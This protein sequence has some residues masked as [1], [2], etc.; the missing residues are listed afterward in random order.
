MK[1]VMMFM[2]AFI[3]CIKMSKN[4][5][6]PTSATSEVKEIIW[7]VTGMNMKAKELRVNRSFQNMMGRVCQR[8]CPVVA[9]VCVFFGLL[10]CYR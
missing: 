2:H 3:V 10:S 7:S 8:S 9:V 5:S 4:R 6:L 1:Y